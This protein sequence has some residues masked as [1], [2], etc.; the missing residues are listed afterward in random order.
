MSVKYLNYVNL[1]S[2]SEE[3][4]NKR[5]PLPPPRKKSLSP[6]Q[7]PSK[8]IS[9]KSTHYTSSSSPMSPNHPYVQ[10]M[11]NGLSGPSNPSPPPCVSRPP[12]GFPNPPPKFKPLTSTQPLFVNI[13]NN[14]PLI[15]NNAPPLEDIH[16]P[17]PNL[18]NQDFH[19]HPNILDFFILTTCL[20]STTCFINVKDDKEKDKIRT[21]PNKIESKREAWKSPTKSKPSHSQESNKEKKIQ[22]KET[23]TGDLGDKIICDLDK[24]TDF[25]QRSPQNCPKCGNPVK[26]DYCQGCA[27]LRKK[28]KED[29]FASAIK[30][31]I[32]Q[33]S[34][35][36]S[37]DNSNVA[38]APRDPFVVNQDPDKD[39]SQSPPQINHHCCY[40]CGD[41]LEGIFCHRC[42]LKLCGNGAHYGYNCPLK[43]PIIPDPKSFTNQAIKELPPTMQNVDPKYDLVHKSPNVFNLPSQLP[44]ISCEFCRNDACYGYYCTP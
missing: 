19:N 36:P 31:G 41:P 33:D 11:D 21:K 2:S 24:T 26:G 28:F 29:L 9:S 3:Q 35:E 5:T 6:P 4:L 43:V 7:T 18:G 12:P 22:T 39:S 16:H 37:N 23:K 15:H 44:F 13:N 32:I 40:G 34:F 27:A 38:N 14:T 8:S 10:T 25:S 20:T 42:T 1:T 17:P 30:H